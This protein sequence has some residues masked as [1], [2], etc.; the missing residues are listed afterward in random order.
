MRGSAGAFYYEKLTYLVTRILRLPEDAGL[1]PALQQ[2]TEELRRGE[3][4]PLLGANSALPRAVRIA[5][6]AAVHTPR[7]LRLAC[8]LLLRDRA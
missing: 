7:L 6:R 1:A 3:K 5:A 4:D 2:L 8:R